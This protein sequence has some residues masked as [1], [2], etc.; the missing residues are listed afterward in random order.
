MLENVTEVWISNLRDT[1]E[2][3]MADAGLTTEETELLIDHFSDV[4]NA[5]KPEIERLL[6]RLRK[7]AK[8][9]E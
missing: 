9:T 3:I 2:G 5:I 6:T 4:D 1:V 7:S 8:I